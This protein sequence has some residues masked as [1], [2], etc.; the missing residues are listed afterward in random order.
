MVVSRITIFDGHTYYPGEE[1]P[2]LGS[3]ECVRAE[4][5]ERHYVGLSKDISK[6]P[7]Y[8]DLE[9]DSTAYCTDTSDVYVYLAGDE[10]WYKKKDSGGGG[11]SI[12][13]EEKQE[14]IE[15]AVLVAKNEIVGNA[16]ADYNT[17]GKIEG[18]IENLDTPTPMSD[19]DIRALFN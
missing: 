16:S 18:V 13:P 7:K 15:D 19:E 3:F 14:I 6:L 2:D 1:L 8:S 9:S 12:T 10:T 17:L 11:G 5:G 4:G